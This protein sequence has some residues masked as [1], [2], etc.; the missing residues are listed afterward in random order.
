[1][2]VFVFVF[3]TLVNFTIGM[4]DRKMDTLVDALIECGSLV[5]VVEPRYQTRYQHIM[6][7]FQ[8]ESAPTSSSQSLQHSPKQSASSSSPP[9]PTSRCYLH[10]SMFGDVR[11]SSTKQYL[12]PRKQIELTF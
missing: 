7:S 10:I 9:P 12:L 11:L 6:Q 1:M 8:T 2:F 5:N 3:G 4:V